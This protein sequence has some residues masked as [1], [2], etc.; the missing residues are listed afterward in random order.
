[1]NRC[2]RTSRKNRGSRAIF[3]RLKFSPREREK[4]KK[5]INAMKR[6]GQTRPCFNVFHPRFESHRGERVTSPPPFLPLSPF[7]V[8]PPSFGRFLL[9]FS[10]LIIISNV[11][12]ASC[13]NNKRYIYTYV[14][15]V[16][17]FGSERARFSS[18]SCRQNPRRRTSLYARRERERERDQKSPW[19]WVRKWN[20]FSAHIIGSRFDWAPLWE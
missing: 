14:P 13:T 8:V 7:L 17:I 9:S 18:P 15:C 1:M 19:R 11:V 16:C 10:L 2:E 6:R 5:K 20:R 4:R 3:R 12:T